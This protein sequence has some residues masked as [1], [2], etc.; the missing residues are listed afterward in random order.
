MKRGMK[1]DDIHALSFIDKWF[2]TQLKELVDVE[3]HL[4]SWSLFDTTKEDFFELK[5]RG[6]SDKQIAYATRSNEEDVRSKRISLDVTPAYQRVDTCAAE[7]DA[8]TPYMY[9]SYDFECESSPTTMT[10]KVLILGEGPNRIGQGIE[11]N[12]CCCHTSFALR[13][14]GYETIMMNSNPEIVSTDYDTS[15]RLYFE[16][17]TVEDVLNNVLMESSCNLVLPFEKSQGCDVA[18]GPEMR[19]TGEVMGIDYKSPL[20][21]AKAQIAAGQKLPLSGT[22]FLSLNDITKRAL[23]KIA[24]AFIYLGFKVVS[25]SGTAHV[26]ESE[27]IPVE[28]VLKMHGGRPHAGGM[29][30]NGQIQLMVITSSG[31]ALI[32]LTDDS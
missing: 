2:L 12:Y 26:L 22:A 32:R 1:V 18:L 31:D 17:L 28:R 16:P 13:E 27:E 20:A 3:Q 11:F 14:S 21:F 7:F 6:F 4:M 10:K 25:T 19:S 5:R 30:A 29:V 23:P 8:N 9:S 15:D 24:R